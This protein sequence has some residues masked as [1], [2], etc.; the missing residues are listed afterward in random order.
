MKGE[1]ILTSELPGWWHIVWT[2]FLAWPPKDPRGNWGDLSDLYA[3]LAAQ[4]GSIPMSD[5]LPGRW[6]GKPNP[7]EALVLSPAARELL[8]T[9]LHE[10]AET[11][12]LAGDTPIRALAVQPQAVQIVLACPAEELQQRI[13]RLKSRSATLLSFDPSTGIAGEGTWSKG[14]W[15][16]RLEREELVQA[17]EAFVANSSPA[18]G[19]AS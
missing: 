9:S 2:T 11:D 19:P 7:A 1:P 5:P 10:L 3:G 8:A 18:N 12:R 13:G 4:H 17:A 14:F 15:W 6:Q 16:A